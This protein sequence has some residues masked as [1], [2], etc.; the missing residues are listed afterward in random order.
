[1][2]YIGLM[3]GTSI[4]GIDAVLIAAGEHGRFR[5]LAS[6][7]HP[8]P[9]EVRAEIQSLT[10]GTGQK[11]DGNELDRAMELD[12]LVGRLFADAANV[13]LEKSGLR[14][15]QVRAIGSHGQTLRH[16][17]G[18]IHPYTLQIANP[19]M[20]AERTGITTVADF[21]ARDM[22]AGGQGAPLVPAFHQW[23]FHQDN[24]NRVIVN[25]GGIANITY[26]PGN[27]SLPVTGFD[28]GPGNTLLDQWIEKKLSRHYDRDGEWAASGQASETLL[29]ELLGDAYFAL[30][31][32]KSTGREH[33]NLSW[34]QSRLNKLHPAPS[35]VDVQA[36]LAELTA[37]SIALE[38]QHLPAVHEVF[39]CGGGAHN[40]HLMARLK[41]AL[42]TIP[43]DTTD[44]LGLHPDW[45]EAAA[46]AWLA[47]R[48][49]EGEPGNLPSV[50]G[51]HH[52]VILG[53]I[54]KA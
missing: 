18:A 33:F 11:Q 35:A 6:H 16:G 14:R 19:S 43:V 44:A 42:G 54:Y 37:R 32:P 13:V 34:L 29:A 39:V 8:Y 50:T 2:Y 53:G 17:P 51:A 9:T 23:L 27:D 41:A 24:R 36:S 30:T 4:D 52:P 7:N 22:A 1:M 15:D 20:I 31:P 48:S 40:H 21:R 3:S 12:M 38:I 49:V 47:H 28:T 10:S 26:L 46:F 45:V 25:I 5:L